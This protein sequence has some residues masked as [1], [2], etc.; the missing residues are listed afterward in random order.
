M[1]APVT[2]TPRNQRGATML[3]FHGEAID[4]AMKGEGT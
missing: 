2:D 3:S 1:T 4:A